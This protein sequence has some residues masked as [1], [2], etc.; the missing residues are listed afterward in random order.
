M[1]AILNEKR[2]TELHDVHAGVRAG[3]R[4]G[5]TLLPEIHG[6]VLSGGQAGNVDELHR[7][8]HPLGSGHPQGLR[9]PREERHVLAS[10]GSR[11]QIRARVRRVTKVLVLPVIVTWVWWFRA[12]STTKFLAGACY[13]ASLSVL[14]GAFATKIPL[15]I[16]SPANL[17]GV[18]IL[19]PV[20]ALTAFLAGVYYSLWRDHRKRRKPSRLV[21]WVTRLRFGRLVIVR[22]PAT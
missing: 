18:M 14:A 20:V 8:L 2:T 6:N 11:W 19:A 9:M 17:I 12:R 5:P 15:V 21:G 4:G 3:R 7:Q 1:V 16:T 22:M 10:A 13:W